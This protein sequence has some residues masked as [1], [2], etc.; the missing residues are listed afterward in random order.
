MSLHQPLVKKLTSQIRIECFSQHRCKCFLFGGINFGRFLKIVRNDVEPVLVDKVVI[1][2]V[3]TFWVI[4][5]YNEETNFPFSSE[6]TLPKR[7]FENVWR[8]GSISRRHNT[9]VLMHDCQPGG[10]RLNLKIARS[11]LTNHQFKNRMGEVMFKI[12]AV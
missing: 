10:S 7:N 5:N 1:N 12:S 2:F 11:F 4:G 8:K 9:C 3:I 6:M